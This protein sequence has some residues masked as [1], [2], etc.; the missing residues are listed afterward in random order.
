MTNKNETIM[1]LLGR[2]QLAYAAYAD[3][4]EKELEADKALYAIKEPARP[5]IITDENQLDEYDNACAAFNEQKQKAQAAIY[6]LQNVRADA[7]NNLLTVLPEF[8]MWFRTDNGFVRKT[9]RQG[10]EFVSFWNLLH[11]MQVLP[12]DRL[13]G[14]R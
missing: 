6:P 1:S 12:E 2:I 7:A 3:A 8:D 11:L 5:F 14:G 9:Q 10:I 13:K 4:A